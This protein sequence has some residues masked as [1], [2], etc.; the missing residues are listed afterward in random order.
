MK[1]LDEIDEIIKKAS[2]KRIAGKVY[3]MHN[4]YQTKREVLKYKKILERR[5]PKASV[6]TVS[7]PKYAAEWKYGL[8]IKK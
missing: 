3:E 7:M 6:R 8:Y 1:F 5:Y 4:L 2:K